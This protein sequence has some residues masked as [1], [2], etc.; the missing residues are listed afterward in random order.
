MADRKK[1]IRKRRQLIT[2]ANK[3][4]IVIYQTPDGT[5]ALDVRL[6]QETLWLTQ[7]QIAK[8][9]QKERS[10][11]TKHLR[12]IFK[13]GELK[14]ES[15]VQKMHIA[16]S[17]KP[18][19]F[20]NLDVVISVGYRVNSKR[21]TQFRIWATQVL[22][23]HLLKGYT[24][25][26][27]R[28]KELRQSLRLIE[29]VLDHQE[30]TSGQAR[31]LLRVVTNYSYA[32]DLLDDY[33]HQRVTVGPTRTGKFAGVSYDEARKIIDCLRKKF[34]VSELFGKEKDKSLDSSLSAVFQT[35]DGRELYPS[36]EEKAAHLLYFVVKNHSFIDGNKRI[37]A[38]LFLWFLE[39]NA[40]LQREDGT[41]RIADNAI[42][43]MTLLIAESKPE[44]KSI[45]INIVVNLINNRN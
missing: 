27:R 40:M 8:L 36:F 41:K 44:E 39:K 42:V 26:K 9:F 2:G 6:E 18:V 28:L 7:A 37:A 34:A 21:G 5:A 11:I 43:A 15:N 38:A 45:I 19:A 31:D 10:V 35:F 30:V 25:N 1:S 13:E 33:D 20:F 4:E 32:L 14:Q 23:E 12:N 29:Q 24:V 22:R 3:G 16:A 17:D